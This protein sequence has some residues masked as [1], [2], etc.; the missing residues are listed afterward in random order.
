[1]INR[2]KSGNMLILSILLIGLIVSGLVVGLGFYVMYADQKRGQSQ[3]D[4]IA[5]NMAESLN[6][7]NRIGQMNTIVEHSRQLAY[8]S[9]AQLGVVMTNPTLVAYIPLAKELCS[10]AATGVNKVD[11][12]RQNQISIAIANCHNYAERIAN[13]SG[14]MKLLSWFIGNR[15]TINTVEFGSIKNT[16]CSSESP[17]L[18]SNLHT[19][20]LQCKYTV[21]NSNLYFGNINATLASPDQDLPFYFSA[22]SPLTLGSTSATRLA[23]IEAFDSLAVIF[24][25]QKSTMALP[26]Q[27][28]GAIRVVGT[29]H[30]QTGKVG[31]QVDLKV[32]SI[33]SVPGA[34]ER[35]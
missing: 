9:R 21:Q 13:K 30:I 25:S 19:Y 5:L 35:L 1:M 8:T 23:N 16:L 28:P 3:V 31:G 6:A 15:V 12:E 32:G 2:T 17:T 20:D 29:M 14:T 34:L 7:D 18:L 4:E 22:L 24:D 11:A 27:L 26:A 10:D 33:A